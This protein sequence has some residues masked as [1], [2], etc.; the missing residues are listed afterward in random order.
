MKLWVPDTIISTENDNP[1]IW[2]Y[3]SEDGYVYRTDSF[4]PRNIESQIIG[5]AT[6]GEIVGVLKKVI[7]GGELEYS[8]RITIFRARSNSKLFIWLY[9]QLISPK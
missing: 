8:E 3:T 2:I 6:S 4:F 1:P 9:F 5:D 7:W